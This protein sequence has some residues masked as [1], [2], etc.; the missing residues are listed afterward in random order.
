M[1]SSPKLFDILAR[2]KGKRVAVIGDYMLDRHIQGSVKRISPEAPVPVVEIEDERSSLG[3]AGNVVASLASGGIQP[4]GFGAC[5]MD[6]ARDLMHQ[7]LLNYRCDCS[8][9]LELADRRTTEK[10][11][12]IA[13]D[14]HVVRVDRETSHPLADGRVA[15]LLS[16]LETTLPSLDAIIL[17]D[18]NKG[19][20]TSKVIQRSMELATKHNIPVAVDPKFDNF[21]LYRGAH[22][23]KPNLREAERAL[24]MKISDDASL[25]AA[26]KRLINELDP[27]VLMVTRGEKGMTICT[28]EKKTSIPTHARD[29]ADV[30]GAGDT[31]ISTFVACELGGASVIEAARLA[32]IAAGIVC[33]QVG[34]VPIDSDR[35]AVAYERFE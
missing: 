6:S 13:H 16:K 4:V 31:V 12:I 26:L 22:L 18:Y 35:L 3:G 7:H 1:S 33:E 30:S 8:G 17:Q 24:G 15:Q 2:A 34:V 23:F 32:N 20:L 29:V 11:R 14:Q 27:E 21:T 9:L 25:D 10:T 19:V 5:G 28:R